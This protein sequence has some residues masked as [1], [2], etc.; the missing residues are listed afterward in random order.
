MNHVLKLDQVLFNQTLYGVVNC[1]QY[2]LHRHVCMSSEVKA[3]T[4]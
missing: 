3:S 2:L 1:I 4:V